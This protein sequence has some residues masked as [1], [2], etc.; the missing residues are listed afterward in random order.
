MIQT[1]NSEEDNFITSLCSSICLVPCL[2]L[3]KIWF[4]PLNWGISKCLGTFENFTIFS[5]EL[6]TVPVH[7]GK[8]SFRWSLRIIVLLASIIMGITISVSEY[9]MFYYFV[10][11]VKE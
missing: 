2:N 6:T 7:L 3:F 10:L 9:S 11:P 5:K 8:F 1:E 4:W